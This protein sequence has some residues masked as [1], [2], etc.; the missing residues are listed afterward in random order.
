MNI[1]NPIIKIEPIGY[2]GSLLG[3]NYYVY[4]SMQ[5][6]INNLVRSKTLPMY[7]RDNVAVMQ[8]IDTIMTMITDGD[9]TIECDSRFPALKQ[10]INNNYGGDE[11]RELMPSSLEAIREGCICP[12]DLNNQGAGFTVKGLS[13]PFYYTSKDCPLH[14]DWEKRVNEIVARTH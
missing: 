4:L 9:V 11:M 10:I 2:F 1:Y 5:M 3:H 8:H 7:C 14:H 6:D 12:E 13:I